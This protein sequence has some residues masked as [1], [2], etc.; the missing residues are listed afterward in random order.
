MGEIMD[1]SNTQGAFPFLFSFLI[2]CTDPTWTCE[3]S[4]VTQMAHGTTPPTTAQRLA[5]CWYAPFGLNE[6]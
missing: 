5:N 3:R 4:Q 6:A 2:L 1:T